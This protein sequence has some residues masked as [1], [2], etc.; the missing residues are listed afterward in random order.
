MCGLDGADGGNAPGRRFP[1]RPISLIVPYPAG[2]GADTVGG[3][4][5]QKLSEALGQQVLVVNRRGAGTVIG[6]RDAARS[7]PDGYTILMMVTG[8]WSLNRLSS[9]RPRRLMGGLSPIPA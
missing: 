5:A 6:V 9:E 1:A 8:L 3:V 2:G 7:A 4:I